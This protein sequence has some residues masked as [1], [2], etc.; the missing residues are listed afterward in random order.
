MKSRAGN[1]PGSVI[2]G[3]PCEGTF[4]IFR[5]R[6]GA[7]HPF[8]SLFF[9]TIEAI[10]NDFTM[11][12]GERR[13]TWALG[14]VFSLRMLGMFMVLPVLTTYGMSLAGASEALIGLAIGIYGMTQALFQ[15]PFGL[16]S[17]KVGR[18]PLIVGGLLMFAL[19][20]VIAA[21]SDAIWGVIVGR[22][23]QGAAPS[24]PP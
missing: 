20:S 21:L 12:R 23:L 16:L 5:G 17:D 24:P 18:K 7:C 22:A 1:L 4:P 8:L 2:M 14:S 11:T 10:M 3:P 13:A 6:P 9:L 19:G 15:I